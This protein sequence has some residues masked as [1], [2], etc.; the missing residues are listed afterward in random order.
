MTMLQ[1]TTGGRG[2]PEGATPLMMAAQ[3]RSS[4]AVDVLLQAGADPNIADPRR[5]TALCAALQSADLAMID[6]LCAV[7]TTTDGR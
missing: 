1:A 6:K 4:E 2:N 3:S 7:T 5:G